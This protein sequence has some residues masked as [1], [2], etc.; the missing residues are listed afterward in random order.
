MGYETTVYITK[1]IE[2]KI[3][4]GFEDS[5]P[6]AVLHESFHGTI[7]SLYALE[8]TVERKYSKELNDFSD[9]AQFTSHSDLCHVTEQD[10]SDLDVQL[11]GNKYDM[12]LRYIL[13]ILLLYYTR[14]MLFGNSRCKRESKDL[15]Y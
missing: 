10:N 11:S 7:T 4:V 1:I 9:T 3:V 2:T 15:W 8:N 13:Q 12:K 14:K 6:A 5:V